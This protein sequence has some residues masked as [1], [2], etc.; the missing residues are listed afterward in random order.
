MSSTL[1]TKISPSALK[2]III[3]PIKK[4]KKTDATNQQVSELARKINKYLT[5]E[6]LALLRTGH[7]KK[8][9]HLELKDYLNINIDL[10]PYI[11]CLKSEKQVTFVQKLAVRYLQ[12]PKAPTPGPIIITVR[13]SKF[14]KPPPPIII[15]QQPPRPITPETLIL[16]EKPPKNLEPK[17][18]ISVLLLFSH[19]IV[20]K[21]M[22]SCSI[23]SNA[24]NLS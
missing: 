4:S 2:A 16:R 17:G 13:K 9:S 20:K 21:L 1:S 10:N 18:N 6:E 7:Q 15:R 12:P 11:V 24:N 3:R 14:M 23:E 19:H 5:D 22:V 8:C